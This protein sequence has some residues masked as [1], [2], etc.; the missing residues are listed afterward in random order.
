[1][2]VPCPYMIP[3]ICSAIHLGPCVSQ[4]M[5]ETSHGYLVADV[6]IKR[7]FPASWLDPVLELTWHPRGPQR[8]KY[9]AVIRKSSQRSS[10]VLKKILKELEKAA[11]VCQEFTKWNMSKKIT[12]RTLRTIRKLFNYLRVDWDCSPGL[13]LAPEK[14]KTLLNMPG[15]SPRVLPGMDLPPTKRKL[16]NYLGGVWGCHHLRLQL[17][18]GNAKKLHSCLEGIPER[19]WEWTCL[20][21]GQSS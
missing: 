5:M 7:A 18:L 15:R 1:M 9:K 3:L 20:Q 4:Y 12:I 16:F 13:Q 14:A 21:H 19:Y 2:Y 8:A 6:A 11:H 10:D 17:S